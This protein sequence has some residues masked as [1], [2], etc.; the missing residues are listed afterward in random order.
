MLALSALAFVT[1]AA[2]SAPLPDLKK[3]PG[4]VRSGLSLK[5]I[6]TTKWGLDKRHVSV[7]MKTAVFQEYGLSGNTDPFCIPKGCEIDHLVSR[8][9]GGA[10]DVKNLWP[11]SYSGVWNAHMKDRVENRLHKE[12]CAGAVT[13]KAARTDITND[14]TAVYKR[15]FGSPP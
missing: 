10:D 2:L 7:A 14:W 5:T 13:L 12:V 4:L 6:C 1:T 9:L 15:Y 11:Q 8:E 3:T